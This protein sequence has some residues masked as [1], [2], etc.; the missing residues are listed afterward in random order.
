MDGSSPAGPCRCHASV[1]SSRG[2]VY[3]FPG[4]PTLES[5]MPSTN[6][7]HFPDAASVLI[8]MT[9]IPGSGATIGAAPPAA[10]PGYRIL[11]TLEVDEYDRPVPTAAIMDLG[12][13]RPA[14]TDNT[15]RGNARKAAKL[16]IADANME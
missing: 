13:P 12:A 8:A 15:F 5:E 16:S 2:R 7:E 1:V 3:A 10:R 14:P 11:R 9:L 4:V 6:T